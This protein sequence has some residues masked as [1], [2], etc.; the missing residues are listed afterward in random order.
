MT[1]EEFKEYIEVWN[2]EYSAMCEYGG[3]TLEWRI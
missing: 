3:I 1:Q 2:K